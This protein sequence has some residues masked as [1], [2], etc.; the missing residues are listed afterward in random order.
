MAPPSRTTYVVVVRSFDI[1]GAD[2]TVVVVVGE[3]G[4]MKSSFTNH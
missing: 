1:Y 3:Y 2:D 4:A